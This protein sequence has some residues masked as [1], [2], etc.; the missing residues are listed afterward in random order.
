M[1]KL[2]SGL[3]GTALPATQRSGAMSSLPSPLL[4]QINTT[5]LLR[6]LPALFSVAADNLPTCAQDEYAARDQIQ[7]L[8]SAFLWNLQHISL[9]S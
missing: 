2:S 3:P 6:S 5:D 7:Y 9:L 8:T 1:P 4:G